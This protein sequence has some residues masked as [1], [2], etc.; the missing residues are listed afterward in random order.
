MRYLFTFL[1]TAVTVIILNTSDSFAQRKKL[2]QTG[3]KFLS[4]STDARATAMGEAVTSLN[5]GS[6]SMLYN[7]STMAELSSDADLSFGHTSWIAEI[8]YWGGTAAFK[9]FDG[10]YGVVGVSMIYVDYGE[11]NQTIFAENE[12]GY[13]DVGTYRPSAFAVGIG[14]AKSLSQKFSVGGNLRYV[15]QSLGSSVL[16][17]DASGNLVKETN[18]VG[19]MSFDFGVLYHTGYKSLDFGM[20]VRN[21]STEVKYKEENFQLPLTFKIG[22]SFNAADLLPVDRSLHAILVSVDASHPRDYSE[23]IY[24]GGEYTFMKSFSIRAGYNFPQDEGGF[25]A[26]FGIAQSIVGLKIGVDYAYSS[27]GIFNDTNDLFGNFKGIHRL[28]VSFAY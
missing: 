11:L 13:L 6:S 19:V 27:F 4:V 2:A 15:R 9:P 3:M 22:L 28:T 10:E 21:F 8:N 25:N 26:G 24:L 20:C 16:D 17:V 1:I 5:S 18:A 12:Q 14:Y 23:Q 7:P